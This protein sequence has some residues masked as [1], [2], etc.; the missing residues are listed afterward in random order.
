[1]KNHL[2]ILPIQSNDKRAFKIKTKQ[3]GIVPTTEY[4]VEDKHTAQNLTTVNY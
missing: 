3:A 2:I 4:C 1:M